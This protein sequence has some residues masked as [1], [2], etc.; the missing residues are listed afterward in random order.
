M[1]KITENTMLLMLTELARQD[2][3]MGWQEQMARF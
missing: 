3:I 2:G 1:R